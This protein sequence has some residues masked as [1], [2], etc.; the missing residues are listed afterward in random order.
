[1]TKIELMYV[2][3]YHDRHGR[4][5]HYFRK[6][7]RRTALPGLPGGPAFMAAYEAAIA[8][9]EP[10]KATRRAP[11]EGTV[12]F[13]AQAF[14]RSTEF[15]NLKPKS[16][17][18]YRLVLERFAVADGHRIAKDLPKTTARKIIEEIGETSP[19]MANLTRSV[20]R[21]VWT[22]AGIAANPFVKLPSYKM[23]THH[24]WT[25]AELRAY[26]KRWKVGTPERLY[27]D[28][29]LYTAQRVGDAV[30][31]TRAE[32]KRGKL[33]VVQEK[34]G[35]ELTI[36]VH[37]ALAKSIKATPGKGDLLLAD[38]EGRPMTGDRLSR[39]VVVA[40]RLAGLPEKCVPH[41]LRKAAMRRLAERGGT[42]HELQAMSG[43]KSL[44]EVQNYTA[45]ASQTKLAEAAVRKM[46]VANRQKKS[47]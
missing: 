31:F 23:G 17:K 25:E 41:G 6:G 44:K 29:L 8:G 3:Q 24:T 32:A 11:R 15:K 47:G 21:K 16:Q 26:E 7:K 40:T 42:V 19:G 13:I 45:K 34:T 39:R 33:H 36:G 38:E 1:M 46:T 43:H 2:H 22:F 30:K 27:F 10:K 37:P 20:L 9:I 4:Q 35:A 5:R 14:L 18:V 28:A 12:N